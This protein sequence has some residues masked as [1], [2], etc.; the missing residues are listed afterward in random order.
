ME[1]HTNL[2]NQGTV[3][4]L[5]RVLKDLQVSCM[6]LEYRGM[7]YMLLPINIRTLPPSHPCAIR[8]IRGSVRPPVHS[9]AG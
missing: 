7:Q 6:M 5:N 3:L 8:I 4:M 2:V 9:N 1:E